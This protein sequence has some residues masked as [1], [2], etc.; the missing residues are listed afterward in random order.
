MSN[1]PIPAIVLGASGYVGAE[2]IRLILGH[3]R[4]SL[5]CATSDSF[6]NA[7]LVSHFP[8]L[9]VQLTGETFQPLARAFE[10]AESGSEVAVFSALPHG[11][12]API[13]GCLI[14]KAPHAKIVDASADMRFPGSNEWDDQFTCALPDLLPTA[15]TPH[16]A[17]PGCFT[18]AVTLGLA[19]LLATGLAHPKFQASAITGSTGSGKTPGAGTHHPHRNSSLWAYQPLTHRHSREMK[20]LLSRYGEEVDLAFVPHSGP[21]ARGIHATL[22]GELKDLTP[23]ENVVKSIQDFY[24]N[25]PFISVSANPPTLKEVVGSNRCHIG[26][27]VEGSQIVV[28]SVIDNLVKGAAG[29]AMQWMNR[30]FGIAE[31]EGLNV[32]M[33]GWL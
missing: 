28:T 1:F 21:F 15:P 16:I 31:T 9:S 3:P 25:S 20:M 17:H 18:T 6:A 7:T 8:H 13:L 2:F 19:G 10:I 11:E 23:L 27:A 24:S 30:L 32:A 22:F 5:A 33:P 29:G 4:F 14:D 12:A 26:I